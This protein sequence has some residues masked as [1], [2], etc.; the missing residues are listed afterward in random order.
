MDEQRVK[1]MMI[2]VGRRLD[3][4]GLLVGT[5]GNFS[6]RTGED[7]VLITASGLCK[8][9]LSPEHITKVDMQ[10]RV[11]CGMKPARDIRM[12]LAVYETKPGARAIVHSHPP[13]VTGFAI[14]GWRFDAVALSEVLFDLGGI[15][16]AGYAAPTTRQVPAA[17]K[18][19]LAQ[20]ADA[21]AVVLAGHG[22][23]TLSEKDIWDAC[24][25]MEV[26]EMVAKSTLV[27]HLA[28]GVK[29]LSSAQIE[30]IRGIISGG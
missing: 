9:M 4:K 5:G 26:L 17:V 14:S 1:R 23:L 11:L 25:N 27:A 7:E 22:A 3:Q 29:P 6:V 10:G 13:V 2:D 19:A 20:N 15:A 18:A 12:H 28:G 16:A 21:K 8:A 30:E 24:F